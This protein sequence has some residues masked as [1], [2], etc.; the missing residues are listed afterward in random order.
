MK[1]RLAALLFA[2]VIGCK[3]EAPA[4]APPAA[5]GAPGPAA[6]GKA[7]GAPAGSPAAPAAPALDPVFAALQGRPQ[8]PDTKPSET[9][10]SAGGVFV[11]LPAGWKTDDTTQID[12][13]AGYAADLGGCLMF[14]PPKNTQAARTDQ[15]ARLCAAAVD[16]LPALTGRTTTSL[17]MYAY[18]LNVT[19]A[20]WEP[21]IDGTVGDG[22][23]AKLSKGTLG[24]AEVFAAYVEIP[25]KKG[26]LVMGRWKNDDEKEAVFEMVRGL[27]SCTFSADKRKCTPD[28]P[29]P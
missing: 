24:A 18:Y 10:N 4:S 5:S 20:K 3:E 2:G 28:K 16:K 1:L 22:L 25:G 14:H 8:K 26:I 21:W 27:G 29:Y 19:K 6:S 17:E 15:H 12:P 23:K 7:A 11:G 9:V 13:T